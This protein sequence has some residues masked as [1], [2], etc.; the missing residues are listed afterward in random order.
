MILSRSQLL[1]EV[2]NRRL[3]LVFGSDVRL[4]DGRTVDETELQEESET[5]GRLRAIL[6]R[7]CEKYAIGIYPKNIGRKDRYVMADALLCRG[8]APP[9]FIEILGSKQAMTP[10]NFRRKRGLDT[11]EAPLRFLVSGFD[12]DCLIGTGDGKGWGAKVAIG[13]KDDVL[14]T[15][16]LESRLTTRGTLRKRVHWRFT[17][18]LAKYLCEHFGLP[19]PPPLRP[20]TPRR[21]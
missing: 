2:A 11:P 20:L 15:G 5:H 7:C 1:A 19:P 17:P 10:E 18:T 14:R 8:E 21:S 9:L 3:G 12:Y 13:K 6:V 4:S 16:Q